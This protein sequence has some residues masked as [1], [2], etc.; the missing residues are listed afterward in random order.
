MT[1]PVTSTRS[2]THHNAGAWARMPHSSRV[3]WCCLA[4]RAALPVSLWIAW[5]GHRFC[6]VSD[7]E[8][9]FGFV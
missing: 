1:G 8:H 9:R 7:A 3:P 2:P 5:R 4:A 6:P